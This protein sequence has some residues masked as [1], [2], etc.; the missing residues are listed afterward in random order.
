MG[1]DELKVRLLDMYMNFRVW[2]VPWYRQC[3]LFHQDT[4]EDE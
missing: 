1:A 2:G 4:G 3:R